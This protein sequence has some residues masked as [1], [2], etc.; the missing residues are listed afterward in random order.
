MTHVADSAAA[1]SLWEMLA[2]DEEIVAD[3]RAVGIN[4]HEPEVPT[5]LDQAR[6]DAIASMLLRRQAEEIQAIGDL[7]R[8]RDAELQFVASRYALQVDRHRSR[9][10]QLDGAVRA[11]AQQTKEA[12]GYMGKRKSRDVGA[13]S[14]GYRSY[15]GAPELASAEA[16]IAWAEVHAPD[17]LRVKITVPLSQAREFLTDAELS[18]CRREVISVAASAKVAALSEMNELVPGWKW[19]PAHDDFYAKPLPAAAIAGARA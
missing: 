8:S 9:A 3:L 11:L 7:E 18:S 19:V 2:L 12:G 10:A 16:Y 17:T 13:G 5:S 15:A 14:Y 1:D 6:R 4:V